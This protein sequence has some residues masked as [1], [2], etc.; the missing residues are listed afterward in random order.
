MFLKTLTPYIL[1]HLVIRN[2]QLKPCNPVPCSA[3]QGVLTE[4]RM[5]PDRVSLLP[6]A[7]LLSPALLQQAA[8]AL[9]ASRGATA[10][11]LLPGQSRGQSGVTAATN[12]VRTPHLH[13]TAL[14]TRVTRFR[15]K[16]LIFLR[17]K[18]NFLNCKIFYVQLC[19]F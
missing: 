10:Q 9:R 8:A 5:Q 18:N 6:A 12:T 3:C 11:T 7:A 2:A 1:R 13:I 15:F 19:H 4:K 17:L 14:G 16:I